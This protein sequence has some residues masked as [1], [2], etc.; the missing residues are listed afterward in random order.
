MSVERS[1]EVWEEVHRHGLDLADRLA[2]GFT[3]LIQSHINPPSFSWPNLQ[4]A[5]LFDVE[6][7]SP[8][9]VKRD[10]GLAVDNSGLNEVSAIF[11]IGTRIG[12]AGV[13]FGACV[14]GVVQHFFRRFPVP[15]RQDENVGVSL[16][17]ELNSHTNEA[18]VTMQ[19]DLGS[20][21]ERF[22]DFGYVE[23]DAVSDGLS[24]EEISEF[25]LKTAGFF[26]GSQVQELHQC[27]LHCCHLLSSSSSPVSPSFRSTGGL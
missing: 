8:S 26:G 15:F 4:N 20:L 1:F 6:F 13:D 23:N 9:F 18:G 3:G 5:K 19:E 24:E 25:N 16:R 21:A 27:Q 22:R 11:D 14:N 12:Q 17:A 2:Q 10:F 7:P